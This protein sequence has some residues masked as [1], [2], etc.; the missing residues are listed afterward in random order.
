MAQISHNY[1]VLPL[2]IFRFTNS[3]N[4]STG[5]PILTN[6]RAHTLLTTLGHLERQ[7]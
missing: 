7:R 2:S 4:I 1:R 3:I 6:T 5:L